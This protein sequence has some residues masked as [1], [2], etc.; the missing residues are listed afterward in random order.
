MSKNSIFADFRRQ[1]KELKKPRNLAIVGMLLAVWLVIAKLTIYITPSIKLDFVFIVHS[2]I[3]AA[4]GPAVGILTGGVSEVL[5][6]MINPKVGAYF[7]G[8]TL[9]LMIDGLIYGIFFYKQEKITWKRVIIARVLITI[10]CNILL[11]T[12]WLTLLYGDGFAALLIPRI[13]KNFIL[14]PVEILLTY[15]VLNRI[16]NIVNSVIRR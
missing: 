5:S 7:P 13:I 2:L 11:N 1:V 12:Y 4:F 9:T 6:Y 10:F 8:F 16:I 3:S 15:F 14:L